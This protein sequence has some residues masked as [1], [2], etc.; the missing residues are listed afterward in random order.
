MTRATWDHLRTLIYAT[1]NDRCGICHASKYI[2]GVTLHC[3]EI[4]QY[5]YEEKADVMCMRSALREQGIRRE[6]IYK[7]DEDTYRLCYGSNYAPTYRA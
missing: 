3:H 1:Y 5:D 6:I 4:W 7:A 2:S